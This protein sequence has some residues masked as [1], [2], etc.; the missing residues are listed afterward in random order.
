MAS[1]RINA[2]VSALFTLL[3]GPAFAL[4]YIPFWI[5]RF[6]LPAGEPWWQQLLAALLIVLGVT[7]GLESMVRFVRVGRGTLLPVIP[8]EH[9]V[10]SGIYRYVRNPMYLGVMVALAGE[11]LL[12]HS[13]ALAKFAAWLW[14]GLHLFIC[15]YE[16]RTLQRRFGESY[17]RYRRNVPRWA[18]RL[19]PWREEEA[20]KTA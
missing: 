13:L 17:M 14:L 19:T 7:P 8:T 1:A 11:V 10:V 6:H 3:G 2:A 20:S 12:F 18:P 15:A 9:L 16:E 4:V 5:T